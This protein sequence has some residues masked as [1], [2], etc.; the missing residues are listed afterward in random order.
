METNLAKKREIPLENW[1]RELYFKNYWNGDLKLSVVWFSSVWFTNASEQGFAI[2]NIV[3]VT[4]LEKFHFIETN[5]FVT[6]IVS[7]EH[8]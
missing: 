5:Y 7:A 8:M 4:S 3:L 2:V 6:L 1:T